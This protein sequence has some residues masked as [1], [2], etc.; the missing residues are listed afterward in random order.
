MQV[1][2]SMSGPKMRGSSGSVSP[3]KSVML[4]FLSSLSSNCSSAGGAGSDSSVTMSAGTDSAVMMLVPPSNVG[5][6]MTGAGAS[7]SSHSGD[8][9][10]WPALSMF[11]ACL[12]GTT[13]CS[14]S[15]VTSSS[16]A[17]MSASMLGPTSPVCS[18]LTILSHQWS[19]SIS[20][21]CTFAC[22]LLISLFLSLHPLQNT[23]CSHRGFLRLWYLGIWIVIGSGWIEA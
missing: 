11:G 14:P 3:R 16:E 22:N 23:V 9:G 7:V 4:T 21:C 2:G 8:G 19:R 13:S 15:V 6:T 10:L 12:W 5:A 1:F 17:L 20:S 18:I